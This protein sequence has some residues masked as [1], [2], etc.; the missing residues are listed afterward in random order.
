VNYSRIEKPDGTT[1]THFL[2]PQHVP[3]EKY[4]DY[5][6]FDHP[7]LRKWKWIGKDDKG[8]PFF[9]E[10][11][12]LVHPKHI[13]QIKAIFEQSRFR[14]ST[15]PLAKAARVALKFSGEM[16]AATLAFSGFHQGQVTLHGLEHRVL[17]P[18]ILPELDLDDPVQRSLV[19]HGLVVGGY[20]AL[21]QFM[22]GLHA[23]SQWIYRTP[24]VGEIGRVYGEYLFNDYIPR[25]K[26][27]M[28]TH[29]YKRNKIRYP[30]K[31]EA[32]IAEL[33]ANQG[34]AAFGELNYRLM[35]RSKTV[36]DAFR[37]MAFAPDFLEARA[38]FVAQ[39][40]KP[41][42]K[43]QRHA[44]LLGLAGQVIITRLLNLAFDG[45]LH[46]DRPL[47]VVAGGREYLAKTIQTD[48]IHF[49]SDRRS[50]F[51][52]RMGIIPKILTEA[53]TGRDAFG[54][55]RAPSEQVKD[56]ATSAVPIPLQ[57]IVDDRGRKLWESLL[58][59]V[60]IAEFKYRT[61]AERMAQKLA[62]E[63][64][65]D[66]TAEEFKALRYR[67]DIRE[68]I[69]EGKITREE[70]QNDPNITKRQRRRLRREAKMS[71]VA[72]LT[73]NR[74]L[75]QA[76]DIWDEANEEERAELYPILKAKRH[77]IKEAH[78]DKRESLTERYEAIREWKN[79]P[80]P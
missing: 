42:G 2:K 38:R 44:L 63:K 9:A 6:P 60:G 30:D 75:E 80:K 10:G 47:A 28:A 41:Y 3:P 39:A 57:S 27:Q 55:R 1:D 58:Q 52:H 13:D 34:N 68:K 43:E 18:D 26:M 22:D 17:R 29:A 32:F 76:F 54:R 21:E 73:K 69:R 49:L 50:F 62:G 24:L 25:L 19:K 70:L 56:V 33:S 65:P 8:A 71:N 78:P 74:S 45:E 11:S 23:N 72:R 48:F 79:T 14:T 61:G 36:Q 77:L 59:G 66:M 7:A 35:G 15:K 53:M 46:N 4:A 67:A 51:Y 31:S 12:M 64:I 37:L 5:K 40:F 20:D 16:K